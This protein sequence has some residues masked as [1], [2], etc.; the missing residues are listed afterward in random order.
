MERVLLEELERGHVE[1]VDG[2]SWV[3]TPLLLARY[4]RAFR[5]SCFES[6]EAA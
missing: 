5:E 4:G 3:A 2:G 1:Q 6:G